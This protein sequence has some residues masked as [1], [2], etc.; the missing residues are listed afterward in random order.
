MRPGTV[1]APKTN[2]CQ[3]RR[4]S[5]GPK[6]SSL[7]ATDQMSTAV[8]RNWPVTQRATAHRTLRMPAAARVPLTITFTTG[9][10]SQA[11]FANANL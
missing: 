9:C 2:V 4:R 8:V 3:A 5:G 1:F 7:F 10:K 11:A 6:P